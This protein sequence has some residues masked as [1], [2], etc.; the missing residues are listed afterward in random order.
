MR[1]RNGTD[2]TDTTCSRPAGESRPFGECALRKQAAR[3]VAEQ[4]EWW[5]RGSA[6]AFETGLFTEL[7][8]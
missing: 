8:K 5:L 3:D 6:R 1:T 4:L 7:P 2:A